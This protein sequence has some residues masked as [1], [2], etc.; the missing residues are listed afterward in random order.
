MKE[1]HIRE[2]LFI[3]LKKLADQTHIRELVILN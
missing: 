3:L 1:A 2:K